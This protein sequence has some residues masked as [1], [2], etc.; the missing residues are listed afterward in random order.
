MNVFNDLS[1]SFGR[2]LLIGPSAKACVVPSTQPG[3]WPYLTPMRLHGVGSAP[4]SILAGCARGAFAA[5]LRSYAVVDPG[6]V[7]SVFDWSPWVQWSDI[8]RLTSNLNAESWYQRT[9]R[10][11]S[12]KQP[13]SLGDREPRNVFHLLTSPL[14]RR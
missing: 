1:V 6:A 14:G 2:S 13:G 7:Q 5:V 10:V 3:T 12:F 11:R 8:G 4:G 9:Y